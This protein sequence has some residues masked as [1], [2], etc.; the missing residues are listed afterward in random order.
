MVEPTGVRWK[1]PETGDDLTWSPFGSG[2]DVD[3]HVPGE[4][5]YP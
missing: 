3:I 5:P 4:K 2:P 1:D